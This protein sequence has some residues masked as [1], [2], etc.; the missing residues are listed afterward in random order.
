MVL[1][2]VQ[3]AKHAQM[4]Q[5]DAGGPARPR[6]AA[7]PPAPN[8]DQLSKIGQDL[9]LKLTALPIAGEKVRVHIGTIDC[10]APYFVRPD[11]A[12]EVEPAKLRGYQPLPVAETRHL[13]DDALDGPCGENRQALSEPMGVKG[14]V[15][16]LSDAAQRPYAERWR[17]KIGEAIA[18]EVA[19]LSASYPGLAAQVRSFWADVQLHWIYTPA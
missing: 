9:L 4:P 13:Y 17:D 11:P 16:L 15:A 8:A 1:P 12:R 14:Y 18:L 7:A 6:P 3:P 10:P 5:P 2:V 19:R